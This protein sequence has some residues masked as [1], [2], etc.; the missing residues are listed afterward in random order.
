MAEWVL[1]GILIG[2]LDITVFQKTERKNKWFPSFVLCFEP[3]NIHEF[4]I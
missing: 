3:E 1:S 2:L 4:V